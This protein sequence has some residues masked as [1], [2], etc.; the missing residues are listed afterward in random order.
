MLPGDPASV[1]LGD[2]ASAATIEAL[3]HK[4]GLDQPLIVQYLDFLGGVVRGDWGVSMATGRPVVQEVLNVL[5]YTIELTLAALVLG[6]AFG[7]PLGI[8]AASCAQDLGPGGKGP[9]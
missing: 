6:L 5:P 8:W 9:G 4:L 1:V 2:Q 7:V 3:R